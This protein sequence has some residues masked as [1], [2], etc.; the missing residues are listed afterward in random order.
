MELP[1]DMAGSISKNRFRIE[2]LW[3][4]SKM[5]AC[6]K[7][8]ADYTII[9]DF[10]CDVEVHKE[11]GLEFYQI[12]TI[13]Q[14]NY[15]TDSLCKV[16]KSNS[17][18]GKLY[19]LFSPNHSINLAVVC[20]KPLS[21]NRKVVEF[22]RCCFA[23]LDEETLDSIKQNLCNELKI[24]EVYFEKMF[25]IYESMDLY[26]PEEAVFGRL[27]KSFEEIKN[28]E[29]RNPNA[30]FRL[31]SDTVKEKASYEREIDSYEEVKKCKGISKS[32]FDRMLDT[33]MCESKNGIIETQDYIKTLPF[34][35]QRKYNKALGEVIEI[36]R[37]DTLKLLKI[38]IYKYIEEHEDEL[39]D[40]DEYLK[41]ARKV[42]DDEFD[43]EFTREMKDVVYILVYKIYSSGGDV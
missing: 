20:N 6:H 24:E 43:R 42:F 34:S 8:G 4:I 1:Y 35:K 28:E 37:I 25:F 38:Q 12:K 15:T 27:I 3:G 40:L 13:K 32:D 19:T 22:E 31:V 5:I 39:D 21:V 33:H 17:I 41:K 7:E 26:H 9:F 29:P 2:L 16:N 18:L 23:E 30:L 36:F 14:N 10:K 11:Q